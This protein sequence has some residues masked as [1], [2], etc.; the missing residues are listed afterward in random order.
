MIDYSE[1]GGRKLLWNN[2]K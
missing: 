1:D 2:R